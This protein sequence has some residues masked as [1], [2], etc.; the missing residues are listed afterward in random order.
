MRF[1]RHKQPS[2][3]LSGTGL[4]FERHPSTSCWATFI[5]SLRD[6]SSRR[7][8]FLV[9]LTRMGDRRIASLAR[10]YPLVAP[11]VKPPRQ[12]LPNT[13]KAI[14]SGNTLISEPKAIML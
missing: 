14:R 12:Y 1:H 7:I 10:P 5:E 4:F 3:V 9:C 6:D 13:T 2:I 8:S 11:V